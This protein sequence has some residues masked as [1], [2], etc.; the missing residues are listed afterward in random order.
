M[1]LGY[2]SYDY[3]LLDMWSWN[4]S[5]SLIVLGCWPDI[6]VPRY[7]SHGSWML[8]IYMYGQDSGLMRGGHI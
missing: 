7:C 2:M 4:I 8:A 1:I 3:W 5:Q 6:M